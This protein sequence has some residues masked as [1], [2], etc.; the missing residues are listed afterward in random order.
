M[1]CAFFLVITRRL[2]FKF[3]RFGTH[4]LFHLHRQVDAYEYGTECSETSAFKLQTPGN[5]PKE[6]IQKNFDNKNGTMY[7]TPGYLVA[8]TTYAFIN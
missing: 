8:T 2:E 4:C 6:S 1:L 3:R 7:T 5:Y